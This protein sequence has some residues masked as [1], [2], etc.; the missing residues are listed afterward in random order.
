M[1][2]DGV[3]YNELQSKM[4]LNTQPDGLQIVGTYQ[5]VVGDAPDEYQL[6]GRV[7]DSRVVTRYGSA[8]GWTVAW[9]N[10]THDSDSVTTW[11]GQYFQIDEERLTTTWLLTVQTTPANLWE[12]TM[13]GFDV[14]T[15]T[16]PSDEEVERRLALGHRS[17]HPLQLV[18]ARG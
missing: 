12:S 5:S 10:G 8:V 18:T 2:I 11:S 6:V 4:T 15:R 7:N 13:V 14:F 16:R 17:S 3:W 1:S 9:V